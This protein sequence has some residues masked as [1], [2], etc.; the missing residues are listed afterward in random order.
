[1]QM[2][3]IFLLFDMQKYFYEIQCHDMHGLSLE[4]DKSKS[5]ERDKS[6]MVTKQ[7]IYEGSL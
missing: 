3:G 7:P 5:L 4:R 6:K 1:M 2:H